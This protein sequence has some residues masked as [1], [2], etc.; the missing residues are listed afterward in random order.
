MGVVRCVGVVASRYLGNGRN[1]RNR[2]GSIP[3]MRLLGAV[4]RTRIRHRT[5]PVEVLDMWMSVAQ[6]VVDWLENLV[7]LFIVGME[8]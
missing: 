7:P 8:G 5:F 3:L 1:R 6:W 2:R 4:A